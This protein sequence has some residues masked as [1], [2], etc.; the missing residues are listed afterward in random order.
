[1]RYVLVTDSPLPAAIVSNALLREDS[2][3][4]L[5]EDAA[6]V[7]QL[8]KRGMHVVTGA[9]GRDASWTKA[10]LG[11]DSVVVL[12]LSDEQHS[13]EASRRCVPT[14]DGRRSTRSG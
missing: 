1:M 9:L 5:C 2:L 10:A 3:L 13:L 14:A 6:L 11:D 4:V 8:R 7:R 12:A